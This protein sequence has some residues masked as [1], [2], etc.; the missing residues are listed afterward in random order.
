MTEYPFPVW[1]K[2]G[3]SFRSGR[4]RKHVHGIIDGVVVL[5]SWRRSKGYW[6]YEAEDMETVALFVAKGLYSDF[7]NAKGTKIDG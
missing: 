7:K 4:L 6:Q 2:K 5:K 3:A 1:C